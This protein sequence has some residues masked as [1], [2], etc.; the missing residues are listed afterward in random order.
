VSVFDQVSSD[1][2]TTLAEIVRDLI[3]V[4][5]HDGVIGI[6]GGSSID[7]AK[8]AAA[9]A[10][11]AGAALDYV[12]RDKIRNTPLPLIAIPTTAGTGSEV[13][14]WSVLSDPTSGDKAS[15]GSDLILPRVAILDP[16]LTYGLPPS[17][18]ASTGMDA[19]SHAVESYGSIW[20]HPIAESLALQA[21]SLV[22]QHL[23]VAVETGTDAAARRGMLMASLIAELAANSTRLGLCHA[24]ALPVGARHHVPHGVA[25]AVLLA[26]VV[27]FNAQADPERYRS[28]GQSLA[29]LDDAIGAIDTLRHDIGMPD[30]FAQWQIGEGGLDGIVA[31]AMMSDNVRANPRKADAADLITILRALLS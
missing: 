5:E 30:T 3:H 21:I 16:V 22:G 19:L 13:T 23:R 28:V 31:K 17:L 10:T 7:V 12:G 4:D 9:L 1:P 24:L 6:G 14:I 27:A 18:T 15:I 29:G 25:N 11:N 20:N 8:A 26:P 2:S